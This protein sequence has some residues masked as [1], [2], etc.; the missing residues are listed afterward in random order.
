MAKKKNKKTTKGSHRE[1]PMKLVL[2]KIIFGLHNFLFVFLEF[3]DVFHN[4]HDF[5]VRHDGL[6]LLL[7]LNP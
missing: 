7:L 3:L 1:E 5:Q 2:L 6:V 4:F